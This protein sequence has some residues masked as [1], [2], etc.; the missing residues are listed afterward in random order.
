[1]H[2]GTLE[3]LL[4]SGTEE[5]VDGVD[6]ILHLA[7]VSNDPSADLDP[8]KTRT[9][10]TDATEQLAL[11]ARANGA[12]FVFASTASIYGDGDF[13]ADEDSTLNPLSH[14]AKSKA[15]AEEALS[16]LADGRW[17]PVILRFGTLFG[18]SPRMRF[19]LV[20]NI[21]G[22]K[23]AQDRKLTV[24][25]DGLQWRPYLHVGDAARALVH[26]AL[27]Q[28]D[29]TANIFNVSHQNLRVV[30]LVDIALEL[31]PGLEVDFA[32]SSPDSRTYRVST[33]RAASTGFTTVHDISEGIAEVRAAVSS[34]LVD[35]PASPI[36]RNAAWLGSR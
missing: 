19:D 6:T 31:D 29:A 7:A 14:Y 32:A 23:M 25:G 11:A 10:N 12:G 27:R 24:Y 13:L 2:R 5:L 34:G 33:D 30:D 9:V 8:A 36:Y 4:V 20:V 17:R 28:P 1:L 35:Q 3:D 26:F 22:M 18:L 21:F 16:H 15:A